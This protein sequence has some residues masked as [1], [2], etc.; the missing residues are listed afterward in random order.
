MNGYLS[1]LTSETTS[2]ALDKLSVTLPKYIW[3]GIMMHLHDTVD[4]IP[5]SIIEPDPYLCVNRLIKELEKDI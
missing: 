5:V 2:M 1:P 3:E 4:N